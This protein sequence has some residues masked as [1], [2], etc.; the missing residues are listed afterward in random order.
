MTEHFKNAVGQLLNELQQ[1]F[2]LPFVTAQLWSLDDLGFHQ[3]LGPKIEGQQIKEMVRKACLDLSSTHYSTISVYPFTTDNNMCATLLLDWEVSLTD[4]Q[5]R[6]NQSQIKPFIPELKKLLTT[7]RWSRLSGSAQQA[8]QLGKVISL[9]LEIE[10]SADISNKY[11]EIHLALSKLMYVENFFVARLSDNK[12][13]IILDY[14]VDQNNKCNKSFQL[15]DGLLY[16]SLTAFVIASKRVLRG[17]SNELLLKMGYECTDKTE[18]LYGFGSLSYDWL[19]V[20]M[21]VGN[22]VIGAVVVQ[23][24]DSDILFKDSDPALIL[25]LAETLATSLHRRQIRE[26]LEK[27]IIQKTSTL[28]ANNLKLES[29]IEQLQISKEKLVEAEKQAALGR[30]VTGMAHELNTPLGVCITAVTNISVTSTQTS[31][32]FTSGKLTQSHFTQYI[33]NI[34]KASH[35]IQSNLH[36]A[37]KLVKQFKQL[38]QPEDPRQYETF[39]MA[40]VLEEMCTT[41][42]HKY[43]EQ[44]KFSIE[45]DCNQCIVVLA[46]KSA[47]RN[48]LEQL[49]DN[50]IRHAFNECSLGVI[51]ISCFE[52]SGYLNLQYQDNGSGMSEDIAKKVFDPFFTT[53]RNKGHAGIGLHA[54]FNIVTVQLNG[55]ISLN[56]TIGTGAIF[57][58]SIPI[59]IKN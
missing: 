31:E 7:D 35:L 42:Q 59:T 47:I 56:N 43:Q 55:N 25:L 49:I 27:E 53:A 29:F 19:G 58:I 40:E 45:F 37:D 13:D 9:A 12:E 24:Y 21:L 5:H 2:T 23:S 26:Q 32:I 10:S 46:N 34:G 52:N 3:V 15:R 57:N 36:R 4:I 20:P 16:G 14:Y 33:A 38:S 17:S 44:D 1:V 50:S 41:S 11:Q 6:T 22:Q 28:S 30:L 18:E 48:L 51:S 54:V 8:D 39:N